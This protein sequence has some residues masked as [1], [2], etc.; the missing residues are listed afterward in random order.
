[1]NALLPR[2]KVHG[3]NGETFE[4]ELTK[5]HITIGRFAEFNDVGLEPDPQQLVSRKA[6]CAL[7]RGADTWWVVDNGSIN[8]TFIRRNQQVEV[9]QGRAPIQD[10]DVIR[11]LGML[12]END[13][14]AY[15]ELVFHDPLRTN[16]VFDELQSAYLEYDW[17]Q[18]RLFRVERFHR[19][20]ITALRPQEH[21]LVRYMDQRNRANGGVAV[22]CTYEELMTAIWGDESGHIEAEVNHLAHGLRQKIELDSGNPQFLQ[23]VRGLGYRLVTRPLK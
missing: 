13:E 4:L 5:D 19:Y 1:M 8:R 11:V 21:K 10:G 15:W 20:E 14:P 9:V 7:E 3:P 18:A 23:S 22:M 16:R 17:V 6:H 2:L 12:Y